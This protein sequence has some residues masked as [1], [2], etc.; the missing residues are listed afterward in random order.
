MRIGAGLARVQSQEHR[1]GEIR[2]LGSWI[3]RLRGLGL[4]LT[5]SIYCFFWSCFH[6]GDNNTIIPLFVKEKLWN[7]NFRYL[8]DSG[9]EIV[10]FPGGNLLFQSESFG[11]SMKLKIGNGSSGGLLN[12]RRADKFLKKSVGAD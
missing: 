10:A 5:Y 7:I 3:L 8:N 2:D 11:L 12:T 1:G 9:N 4:T 6:P